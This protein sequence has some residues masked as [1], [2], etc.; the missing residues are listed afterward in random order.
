[1][2]HVYFCYEAYSAEIVNWEIKIDP[3][4]CVP[5]EIYFQYKDKQDVKENDI[6]FVNDG[7]FLIGRS[8]MVTKLDTKIIIQSHIRKI[9]VYD[10]SIIDPFLLFYLLNTKIVKRQ[11]AAKTFIQAT[12]STLSNRLNEVILPFPRS[13]LLRDGLAQKMRDIIN[14]K[15]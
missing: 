5:E 15:S 10:N 14:L 1:M 7:T 8:A 9:R 11:V 3:V 12:I 13:K 4:K 6:L 2:I